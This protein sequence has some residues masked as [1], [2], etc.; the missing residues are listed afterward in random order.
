M[1][2]QNTQIVISED[3]DGHA[4]LIER[5][6]RRAGIK[7][8]I[9]RFEDGYKT[10][11]YFAKFKE[12]ID[13]RPYNSFILIL[14]LKMPKI[15]GIEVLNEVKKSLLLRKIPIIVFTTTNSPQEVDRCYSLGCSNY[16]QKPIDY[17]EFVNAINLI[18]K[19]LLVNEMPSLERE[20]IYDISR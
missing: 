9:I 15:G 17:T 8:D 11:E 16:V 10:L 18:G 7:N 2:N 14:D 1:M 4:A 20:V 6:L 5:N 19:F 3:N 12:D 13:F